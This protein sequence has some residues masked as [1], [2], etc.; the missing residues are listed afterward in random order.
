MSSLDQLPG[1]SDS[2]SKVRRI[3][4]RNLWLLMFYASELRHVGEGRVGTEDNPDE[5]I[6]LVA[7]ILSFAV[8]ARQRHQ[9]SYGYQNRQAE[10]SRVRGRIDLLTTE[11]R[12]LLSRGK[13]SC[14]F[15]ELTIDTPRMRFVRAALEMVSSL[16]SKKE[17]AHRCRSLARGLMEM[18]VSGNPPSIRMIANERFGQHDKDD[19]LMVEAAKL[20]F[21]L[22]LITEESG[23]TTLLDPDNDEIWFRSLFE[24][25]VY[26]FYSLVFNARGWN[27][28]PQRQFSWQTEKS[29]P[30]VIG[31]LP[32]MRT[33]IVL[34]DP[35]K[36]L[37]I[38]VDTK[39]TSVL[40]AG[41]YHNETVA[42]GYLYQIYSYLHSQNGT[43][44]FS[45]SAAGI[46]LHPSVGIDVDETVQIQGHRIRFA[47]V[48]LS[49]TSQ[50]IRAR[51]IDLVQ[52]WKF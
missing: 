52:Y 9:F 21:E 13:I 27:V 44:E 47:T 6:D 51:L 22:S 16:A 7:E 12:F 3:P 1:A 49:A 2:D 34:E 32:K 17:L 26:G 43:D 28:T 15:D 25:A 38:V 41:Q 36:R 24:K 46:L 5:I 48:D 20:V 11:R 40:K 45:D 30:G 19:R 39:F 18:G 8:A 42:S 4:I 33:D 50:E 37:R 31:I 10:L 29:T 35:A 23:A 14:K